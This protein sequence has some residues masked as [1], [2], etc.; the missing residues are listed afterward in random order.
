MSALIVLSAFDGNKLYFPLPEERKKWKMFSHTPLESGPES[1]AQ[2]FRQ[3][4]LCCSPLLTK[5]SEPQFPTNPILVA[6][7]FLRLSVFS[8]TQ[9][10]IVCHV[11]FS[12]YT[13]IVYDARPNLFVR[14]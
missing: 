7:S 4:L 10:H 3:L 9:S 8:F 14:I 13:F 6:H 5:I 2:C 11:G 12:S 1:R